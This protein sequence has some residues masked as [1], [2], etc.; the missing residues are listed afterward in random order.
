M[1]AK[2]A[3]RSA[4]GAVVLVTA[5]AHPAAAKDV[6][7]QNN[8]VA[9]DVDASFAKAGDND[10]DVSATYTWFP[11]ALDK[12]DEVVPVLRRFVRQPLELGGR[13]IRT[14]DV[15]DTISGLGAFAE[16]WLG[17]IGYG[18]A[19]LGLEYDD[20]VNDPTDEEHAFIAGNARFEAG[21][22][23]LSLLQLGG[24]YRYRPVLI[25][26]P[27]PN[28]LEAIVQERSG[29]TQEFGVAMSFAT[30][31]DRLYVQ[32][33]AGL[34]DVDWSFSG[35]RY[36]GTITGRA[37][38]GQARVSLQMSPEISFFARAEFHDTD[39][40]NER[41]GQ[42]GDGDMATGR[43]PK[44][45]R[46]DV[47]ADAGFIYWFEGKWGFRISLGGG[48]YDKGPLFFQDFESGLLR[49]GVGFTTRY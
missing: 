18:R 43:P 49:V 1:N 26:L 30:P 35:Q 22:R 8:E 37:V 6:E 39:W 36:P 27:E 15:T 23:V 44:M 7:P 25:T 42:S 11:G 16:G 34:R 45:T 31:E 2:P 3:L 19:E 20:V 38:F 28:G 13:L 14:N 17:G 12:N 9:V 47:R 10:S 33:L 5:A 41:L 32:A 46:L 40:D 29:Q 48:Y 4:L 24:F 21:A